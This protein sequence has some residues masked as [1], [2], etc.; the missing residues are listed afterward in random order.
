MGPVLEPERTMSLNCAH[1]MEGAT[2]R[3]IS[4]FS[5][6]P[7]VGPSFPF[8]DLGETPAPWPLPWLLGGVGPLPGVPA[9]AGTFAKLATLCR[10]RS[11]R[12]WGGLCNSGLDWEML[13][14]F[15][16]W[17]KLLLSF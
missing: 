11:G 6:V 14:L 10:P 12:P 5:R 13:V 4:V 7:A 9:E 17:H 3:V 2:S 15:G 8:D 1:R 16:S